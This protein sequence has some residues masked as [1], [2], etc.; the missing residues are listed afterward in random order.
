M[1]AGGADIGGCTWAKA[2][3]PDA[4]SM[5]AITEATTKC[6]VLMDASVARAVTGIPGAAAQARTGEATRT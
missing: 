6:L 5:L 2:L 4:E 1:G 3:V